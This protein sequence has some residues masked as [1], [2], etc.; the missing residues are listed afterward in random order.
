MLCPKFT[1]FAHVYAQSFLVLEE[2]ERSIIKAE[3][4]SALPYLLSTHSY[5][6]GCLP[7]LASTMG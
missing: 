6:E 4:V 2:I 7:I 3:A 1:Y 5:T